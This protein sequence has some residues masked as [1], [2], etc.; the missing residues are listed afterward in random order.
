MLPAKPGPD[1]DIDAD[2]AEAAYKLLGNMA[3]LK[4]ADNRKLGNAGFAEKKSVLAQSGYDLTKWI[5]EAE[6]WGIDEIRQRQRRLAALATKHG[7]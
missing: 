6:A 1:W 2:V 3:L 4:E 5:A 7:R